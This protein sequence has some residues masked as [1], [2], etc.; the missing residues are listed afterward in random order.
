MLC[1]AKQCLTL[2]N[3]LAMFPSNEATCVCQTTGMYFLDAWHYTIASL[4]TQIVMLCRPVP[5]HLV[6]AETAAK[7]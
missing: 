2:S 7:P 6:S 3:V 5:K 4:A 1:Y